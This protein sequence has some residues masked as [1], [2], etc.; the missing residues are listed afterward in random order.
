[1]YTWTY[2]VVYQY[3]NSQPHIESCIY[4]IT[5]STVSDEYVWFPE[6][7]TIKPYKNNDTSLVYLFGALHICCNYSDFTATSPEWW[8]V[9]EIIHEYPYFSYFQVSEL[10]SPHTSMH[11]RSPN[12]SRG[13]FGFPR[14]G[15]RWARGVWQRNLS[16][17]LVLCLSWAISCR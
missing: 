9:R 3:T 11:P 7:R 1:M 10:Y 6:D 14:I 15:Q 5:Y 2:C 12:H 17:L 8:L 13:I 4:N 16:W